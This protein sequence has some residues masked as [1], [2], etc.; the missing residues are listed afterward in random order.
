M[1]P[2]AAYRMPWRKKLPAPPIAAIRYPATAGPSTRASENPIVLSATALTASSRG[3]SSNA[4]VKRAGRSMTFAAPIPIVNANSIQVLTMSSASAAPKASD[5]A[6][7]SA[8]LACMSRR[9][10]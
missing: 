9:R 6:A 1:K 5:T 4:V 3:T 8:W 2:E 7:A 10:S